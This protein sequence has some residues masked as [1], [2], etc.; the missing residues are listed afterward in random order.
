MRSIKG[1][2]NRRLKS[3]IRKLSERTKKIMIILAMGELM[4]MQEERMWAKWA[5]ESSGYYYDHKKG[6]A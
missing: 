4:K 2:A 5:A 3:F 1:K 6:N